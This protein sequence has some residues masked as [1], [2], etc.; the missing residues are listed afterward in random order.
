MWSVKLLTR[1]TEIVIVLSKSDKKQTIMDPQESLKKVQLEIANLTS[2]Q[3]KFKDLLVIAVV[4]QKATSGLETLV[5]S[6]TTDIASLR[7]KELEILKV[8]HCLERERRVSISR[9]CSPAMRLDLNSPVVLGKRARHSLRPKYSRSGSFDEDES[10]S[11]DGLKLRTDRRK[12]LSRPKNEPDGA[13]SIEVLNNIATVG[14]EANNKQTATTTPTRLTT[15]QNELIST[16]CKSKN[17]GVEEFAAVTSKNEICKR[18]VKAHSTMAV[19][20][21]L[22][23]IENERDSTMFKNVSAQNHSIQS[24]PWSAVCVA[25]EP[26]A[27]L[28][29]HENKNFITDKLT[30]GFDKIEQDENVPILRSS[31]QM[32]GADVVAKNV[33][34]ENTGNGAKIVESVETLELEMKNERNSATNNWEIIDTF[35]EPIKKQY[36]L[37]DEFLEI[38]AENLED[39]HGLA[40]KSMSGADTP[41]GH[42]LLQSPASNNLLNKK[43]FEAYETVMTVM[44]ENRQN[45]YEI[46]CNQ[47]KINEKTGKFCVAKAESKINELPP[48]TNSENRFW[49]SSLR[50]STINESQLN[51]EAVEFDEKTTSETKDDNETKMQSDQLNVETP[52]RHEN[53][54]FVTAKN[55]TKNVLLYNSEMMLNE[56]REPTVKEE[57][58][59]TKIKTNELLAEVYSEDG[60]I[61]T[62]SS[63]PI[64]AFPEM[65]NPTEFLFPET[66]A[67]VY[68]NIAAECE[69][70]TKELIPNLLDHVKWK[71]FKTSLTA[72]K[73]IGSKPNF[74][75]LIKIPSCNIGFPWDG[76]FSSF[77]PFQPP[78]AAPPTAANANTKN[79]GKTV[80]N[81]H[82]MTETLAGNFDGYE[83]DIEIPVI[84]WGRR[85]SSDTP[86][87]IQEV[88]KV[89]HQIGMNERENLAIKEDA[90]VEEYSYKSG[91]KCEIKTNAKV[92]IKLRSEIVDDN[93]T[94]AEN[95]I[96]RTSNYDKSDVQQN[97]VNSNFDLSSSE[98]E[99]AKKGSKEPKNEIHPQQEEIQ[100]KSARNRE[101]SDSESNSSGDLNTTRKK[102]R[103]KESQIRNHKKFSPHSETEE[104]REA[105]RESKMLNL[106]A[107]HIHCNNNSAW[108]CLYC[109]DTIY[110]SMYKAQVHVLD[111]HF[112]FQLRFECT[113][114]QSS[115]RKSQELKTHTKQCNS[116]AVDAADPEESISESSEKNI[117]Y[118]TKGKNVVDATSSSNLNSLAV[119]S[120][121]YENT[122]RNI[123]RKIQSVQNRTCS[124]VNLCEDL[125]SND[126]SELRAADVLQS[127]NRSPIPSPNIPELNIG[128]PWDGIPSPI[129]S[130]IDRQNACDQ[131]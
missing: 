33:A 9:I 76:P 80:S 91:E 21:K 116:M 52:E 130:N 95:S 73:W 7:A 49:P 27:E 44:E 6:A 56:L 120:E 23:G 101:S 41:L 89:V 48:V 110:P 59:E 64:H 90:L 18:W 32:P 17:Y 54:V 75:P 65:K 122:I 20:D 51:S 92:L 8:L 111:V 88:S 68:D 112:H 94:V 107:G 47:E 12:Y 87:Q 104:E 77:S 46:I 50:P 13:C 97:L 72:V 5:N 61:L 2:E 26:V 86:C 29:V 19:I 115:F 70:R 22:A 82:K 99:Q 40:S 108:E 1:Q 53:V 119:S 71:N 124:I 109:D 14:S 16:G 96:R 34:L 83:C 127:S 57:K 24:N 66:N 38:E 60:Y 55:I 4:E 36:N 123:D 31:E 15:F 85:I 25:I 42:L 105:K 121:I 103:E 100:Q 129:G 74:P 98:T 79:L 37:S 62:P 102:K 81:W 39:V 43:N 117:E 93:M 58:I 11:E 106:A 28:N 126:I 63:T 84:G 3:S 125:E 131:N 78:A 67:I 45:T 128:F 114:C 69:N 113:V 10:E 118:I 30:S 35:H